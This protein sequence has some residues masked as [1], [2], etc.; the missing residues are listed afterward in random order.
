[1]RCAIVLAAG[2]GGSNVGSVPVLADVLVGE[3]GAGVGPRIGRGLACAVYVER[4]ERSRENSVG[5]DPR[6]VRCGPDLWCRRRRA[7]FAVLL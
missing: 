6:C 5:E 1:M 2:G 3:G 4:K 7:G